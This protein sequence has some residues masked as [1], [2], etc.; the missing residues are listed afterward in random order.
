M[1]PANRT[2]G[3]DKGVRRALPAT[4]DQQTTLTLTDVGGV[5]YQHKDIPV[6][7]AW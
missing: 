1:H 2:Q 7:S 6:L 4:I 3:T 5:A